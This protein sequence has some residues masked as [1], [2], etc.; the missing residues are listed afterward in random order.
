M[1]EQLYHGRDHPAGDQESQ[2]G[3]RANDSLLPALQGAQP[4]LM[5]Q[6]PGNEVVAKVVAH[7]GVGE[8]VG[9]MASD[10]TL[11]LVPL[12]SILGRHP[13]SLT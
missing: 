11:E 10:V 9:L 1:P 4:G 6:V 8:M 3:D 5:D 13:D 12:D 2:H 7:R